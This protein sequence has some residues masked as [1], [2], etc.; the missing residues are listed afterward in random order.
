MLVRERKVGTESISSPT[1]T[2]QSLSL[3]QARRIAIAA[4]GLDR[5]RPA[6]SVAPVTM[7]SLTATIDRIH[8]LQIDSVNVLAR[9]HLMPLFARLGPYDHGLLERSTSAAPRR[10]I[11]AWAHAASFVPTDTWHQLT[12]RRDA[13]RRRWTN[14]DGSFLNRHAAEIDE[15]RAMLRETDRPLTAREVHTRFETRHARGGRGWWDWSIAKEAL[16]HLFFIGE[17]ASAGR[18]TSFERRYDL[19]SRVIPDQVLQAPPPTEG[20]ATRH[21]IELAARAHGVGMISCFADY[22]R[23]GLASAGRAVSELVSSGMLEPVEVEGWRRPTYLHRDAR[24]PRRV[25]GRAVLSP[26]DPLVWERRR[27][28]ALFG[29]T[30][31]IEIYTPATKRQFG[32]YVLPFLLGD[33]IVGKV[34]LKADRPAGVLRVQTAWSEEGA[35][36]GIADDLVAVLREMAGWL[37]L[38]DIEVATPALGDLA[39]AVI[40]ALVRS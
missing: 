5:R 8:L 24:I 7:R 12:F 18:T 32:Y 6:S 25:D 19:T 2:T 27:L 34:D 29:R 1:M 33:S 31:R 13:Y 37:G 23:I 40:D 3:A 20:E 26:F 35:P 4:Q 38:S 10:L 16:E 39:P 21:L 17:V 30:Y 15:V 11:E 9:A 36:A 14:D 22:F 28:L